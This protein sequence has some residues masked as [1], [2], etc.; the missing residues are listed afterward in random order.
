MM[1]RN[2]ATVIGPIGHVAIDEE[3]RLPIV[4]E[5]QPRTRLRR[6][7]FHVIAVQVLIGCRCAPTHDG[8]P[9]LVNSIVWTRTLMS[10]GVVDR[11][12]EQNQVLKE[13]CSGL[14]YGDISQQCK[15]SV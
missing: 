11:N 2:V 5:S 1:I 13:T 8:R 7:R 3:I 12:K 15:P 4:P 14:C 10:V 6:I 9:V